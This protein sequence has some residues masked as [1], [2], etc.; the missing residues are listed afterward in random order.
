MG[1]KERIEL[2]KKIEDITNSKVLVYVT[3]DRQGLETRI[4]SDVIPFIHKH[5]EK[6]GTTPKIN[7]FIYTTGGI[8][9]SGY[10]IVNMIREYC[11]E[12]GIII[13][14]KCLSTG[15]LMTLGA[16]SIIMSKMGQLGPVDPSLEHPLG[17]EITHPQNPAIKVKVPVNVE[18]V[19]SFFNLA[20]K[21][22][23]TDSEEEFTKILTVLAG[24][25]HP[26]VL[27][28]VNR[29]RNEIRFLA[30][31][32]LKQHINDGDKI[33][34]IVKTLIEERFS[35][36]YLI[37]RKEA[38]EDL[39]L[40]I[41]DVSDKLM[42]GIMDL[43]GEYNKL[44]KLDLP[45]NHEM[46]LGQESQTTSTFHRCVVE[47]ENITHT[48]STVAK[49]ERVHI[50]NPENGIPVVQYLQNTIR[51]EWMENDEI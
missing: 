14:F 36:N 27:G 12:F 39:G 40:N 29:S 3:G 41:T 30:K 8:T 19:V 11:K 38:K 18:D 6:I 49:I 5:L 46:E 21:E 48:F 9:V 44:M 26:L 31:T 50:P 16:N 4:S 45:H 28:A 15:T 1:K 37:G 43:Y 10:G 22:A 25:I 13:L 17:P 35:H 7:L 42:A 32:L 23:K 47:S 20:K 33:D 51:E 24:G 2:I 34:S